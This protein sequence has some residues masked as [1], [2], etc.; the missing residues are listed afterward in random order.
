MS[1]DLVSAIRIIPLIDDRQLINKILKSREVDS[2][3]PKISTAFDIDDICCS[4]PADR[5]EYDGSQ[6][7]DDFEYGVRFAGTP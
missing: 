6:G 1:S 5:R 2:N 3:W 7:C 4:E